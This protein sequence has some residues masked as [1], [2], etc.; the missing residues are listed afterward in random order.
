[1][2]LRLFS[3][4]ALSII[5]TA[6]NSLPS[7]EI[8][9]LSAE[10]LYH[11]G[12]ESLAGHGAPRDTKKALQYFEAASEK[13]SPSADN[14]IAVIYDEGIGVKSDKHKALKYYE[15]AAESQETSAQYNLAAYYY[16]ND[17]NHPKLQ[18]YL[19]HTVASKDT[20]ALNLQARIQL[21]NKNFK[22]AYQLFTK[23]AWQQNPEAYFYLYIMN[24]E[25][26][27]TQKNKTK[28]LTYLKKSAELQQPNALFTLGS[29][30][31]KGEGVHKNPTK[32]F[33]LLTEAAKAG[34]T[35]AIVN[36]AI[37]Y[38]K[39]EGVEQNSQKAG[40]LLEIAAAQ[41]DP[42]AIRALKNISN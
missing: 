30:Y 27:G 19:N 32:A 33:Q 21:R 24:Q 10:S 25:G 23:A 11:K 36:L 12:V 28:A 29:M 22:E 7:Q 41:G 39:G 2:Q 8:E 31:L 38:N 42:Q 5:M 20:A 1:M 18:E 6:C 9:T 4:L 14:A 35:Q 37:M 3:T 13:G 34:H 16:E 40:Q 15:K 17:P 26:K